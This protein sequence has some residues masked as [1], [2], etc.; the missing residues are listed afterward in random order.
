MANLLENANPEML[1]EREEGA[2]SGYP[3]GL[4]NIELEQATLGTYLVNNDTMRLTMALKPEH[5]FEPL[6]QRIFSTFLDCW[7]R[8]AG[9]SP[10]TLKHQFDVDPSL[11]DIG[12][13]AYLAKLAASAITVVN[14]QDYARVLIELAQRRALFD[15]CGEASNAI[16]TAKDDD[17]LQTALALAQKFQDVSTGF[18]APIFQ[19]SYQIAE[20]ILEDFKRDVRPYPTGLYDLDSAMDGG[21]FP[22]KSYGFAAR[23]KMG[24][25]ILAGTIS[26]NLNIAGI[27]HLFICGEMSPK[28]IHQRTMARL[29]QVE[30]RLFR[31]RREQTTD[32]LN[33]V[34][35]AALKDNRC[36]IYK[37]AP[38]LTFDELK[39]IILLAKVQK[40]ITGFILDY[41][42]LVGGKARGKSTSEHLDTVAQWIADICR[43]YELWSIVMA[44][45]NQDGN[46][47]GGEGLRLAFDQ[48]YEL[49]APEDDP[50][51]SERWLDMMD[52]RY[53][54]WQSV[55][56]ES[57]PKMFLNKRGPYFDSSPA[58]FL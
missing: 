18:D 37:N 36:I 20:E 47:R 7:G 22:G 11:V 4:L 16:V 56:G 15:A 50:T 3:A 9:F 30:P 33:R 2:I 14:I 43:K 10:I 8:G 39:R 23:K 57:N 49:R 34:A 40:K 6:H 52:T 51:R 1:A 54:Q 58:G 24:K 17:P 45:I 12:G 42:Q 25:T 27:K 21:L 46:T 5:F 35:E 26:C 28:E 29:L 32:F 38:G 44:Q 55:G 48:V 13:G 53:T 31:N 41:W 19:D